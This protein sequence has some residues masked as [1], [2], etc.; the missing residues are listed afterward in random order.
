M[1]A[2]LLADLAAIGAD[3]TRVL[4]GVPIAAGNGVPVPEAQV[5]V[6]SVSQAVSAAARRL[7][8]LDSFTREMDPLAVLGREA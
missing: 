5:Y 7:A 1:E 2:P 8:A 6:R 3:P 4:P